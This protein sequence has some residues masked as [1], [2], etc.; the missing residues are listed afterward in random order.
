MVENSEIPTIGI[1]H[2][3]R[4]GNWIHMK[5]IRKQYACIWLYS[6][7]LYCSNSDKDCIPFPQNSVF[8]YGIGLSHGVLG[9]VT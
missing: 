7:E 9:V 1:Q 5:E 6:V 8:G 4:V 2:V 3:H